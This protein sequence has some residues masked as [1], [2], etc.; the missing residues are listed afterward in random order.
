MRPTILPPAL[1]ADKALA[2]QVADIDESLDCA[3]DF[4]ELIRTD[5]VRTGLRREVAALRKRLADA[6]AGGDARAAAKPVGALAKEAAKLADKASEANGKDLANRAL[7]LLHKARALMAQAMVE[8][9]RIEPPA[10]RLP[11]QREQAA[12]RLALNELEAERCATPGGIAALEKLLPE[13]EAFLQRMEPAR[14]AGDWMRS[15]WLPQRARAEAIVKR[16]PADRCRRS[17][18]AELDFIEADMHRS[19]ARGD[20]RG[21]QAQALPALQRIE[22]LAVRVSAAAPAV[23]RELLRL[24]R[25]LAG[26]GDATLGKRLRALIQVRAGQWPEG[27]DAD[28]IDAALTRYERD[29]ARLA[30]DAAAAPRVMAK[31]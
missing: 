2:R 7:P 27:A 6:L 11:L 17:L 28:A 19:L 13:V 10:L 31:A 30:S 9:G 21:A 4:I 12:L 25:L 3:E 8:V 5:S 18:L 14:R 1:R 29:L 22:R 23:D 26:A 16:V 15:T 20:V 24:A